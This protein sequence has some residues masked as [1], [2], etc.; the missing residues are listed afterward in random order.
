MP[1]TF[2]KLMTEGIIDF[3]L[4]LTGI[5]QYFIE[6]SGPAGTGIGCKYHLTDEWLIPHE[7]KIK[8]IKKQNCINMAGNGKKCLT[9]SQNEVTQC[10]FFICPTA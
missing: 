10:L 8:D 5:I 9:H 3:Q 2:E 4:E 6:K 7:N 1:K